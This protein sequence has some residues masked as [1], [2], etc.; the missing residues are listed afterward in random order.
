MKL[1]HIFFTYY[2]FFYLQVGMERRAKDFTCLTYMTTGCLLEMLVAKKSVSEFTHIIID[3]V[4]ER[5]ED[6]DILLMVV[7][8]LV[9]MKHECSTKVILMSA[10]V[11]TSKFSKYFGTPRSDGNRENAP[12]ISVESTPP[13]HVTEYFL[14]NLRSMPVRSWINATCMC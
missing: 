4:H 1:N 3:E 7:R 10:T 5:D 12:V 14:D 2:T 6:T 11:D 9:Y 13:F 8:K